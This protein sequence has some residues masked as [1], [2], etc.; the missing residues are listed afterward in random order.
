M[1]DAIAIL[2]ELLLSTAFVV[3]ALTAARRREPL[4]ADVAL[5]FGS[6]AAIGVFV[7]V[8]QVA[9]TAATAVGYLV[10]VL[11]FAQPLLVLRLVAKL[12]TVPLRLRQA[13]A[14][15]F[16]ATTA[17]LL[18]TAIGAP[19]GLAV[20]AFLLFI[21]LEAVA[22]IYL[23]LEARRRHGGSRVR[24][25]IAAASTIGFAVGFLTSSSTS[26]TGIPFGQVVVLLS[27]I[28]YVVAFIPPRRLRRIWQSMA[29]LDYAE[30][31]TEMPVAS[32]TDAIWSRFGSA[33]QSITGG[34]A[35]ILE[36]R[37][38]DASRIA[39]S[40]TDMIPP[41]TQYGPGAFEALFGVGTGAFTKL[42]GA[43]GGDQVRR[44]SARYSLVVPLMS[45]RDRLA[46]L[47]V[48]SEHASLFAADDAL[49]LRTLG[50]QAGVLVERRTVLA[51]QENLA[52]RLTSTVDAL[53]S[54]S[55][56]KNDFLAS[57]SHELRT[58]LNAIIGFSQLIADEPERDGAKP[59]PTEW[60]DHIHRGG[61]HLLAL[62]NDVLDL[63][64]VEAGRLE[65]S[66][67]PLELP[68]AIA[69]S[70]AGL[71][72]LAD[73]KHIS[74]RQG[75]DALVLETDRGRFRQVL[76]NLLS[77]AIKYT[78]DGGA[79]SV[80]ARAAHGEVRITV[81]DTGTGIAP[82][83][84]A[85]V[86]EEF[87]QVGDPTARQGGTGLGLALTRRLVEAQ[88][89]RIELES[90][91]GAGSRFTVILPWAADQ[92]A[93][94][95]RTPGTVASAAAGSR[96]DVL[97]VEDDP[98]AVELLRAYL[99]TEGIGVRVAS[100]AAAALV[101]ARRV[102]PAA[103]VLDVLL[104]GI[105][106]W[107]LL[108]TLMADPELRDVPV[109]M[110]TVVDEHELGVALG[111]ADYFLKPV[112]REVLL[113]SLARYAFPAKGRERSVDVLVVDDDVA[114]LD[115]LEGTLSQEG[116]AVAR[117]ESGVAALAMARA[118]P[119][120][121][122]ICDLV[123]PGI[124]GFGV[125]AQL[126]SN[127][128]TR[129]IPILVLT[130]HDLTVEEK[131]RLNGQILGVIGKGDEAVHGLRAW[132]TRIAPRDPAVVRP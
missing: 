117:A 65:F 12:R 47:V 124:D 120:D 96:G 6:F 52:S 102:K 20:P 48:L 118:Q 35:V 66:P 81:A 79:V 51:E 64:K 28:G 77:N 18:A 36:G 56:A 122:I 128:T 68:Q 53:R 130:S 121:L 46:G 74:I 21:L 19:A 69:E 61:E 41:D 108:R 78:P 103:I 82:E 50:D 55:R 98:G 14:V 25:A 112:S 31:L 100:D 37:A 131:R 83:D 105:D 110:V 22:G 49:L 30:R 24:M 107:D 42:A 34:H 23:A 45:T 11:L 54:A 119:P 127:S 38:G 132:L 59:A 126:K 88:G 4:A 87:T 9:P 113:A 123:M 94:A 101:E 26:A 72:P 129:E 76:Y 99:E 116:F 13:I 90:S 63:S 44:T 125:I 92:H 114:A 2:T 104:P 43:A 57:M 106:G 16:V 93:P 115:L 27:A 62:I 75:S 109:I 71:R 1:G 84:H 73:R 29:A 58:P 111:A 86:F 91:L 80:D 95:E 5:I 70:I 7:V 60:V 15:A 40:T 32:P 97:V 8:A 33:A 10:I 85:R 17:G 67:E 89:G 39:A 3:I